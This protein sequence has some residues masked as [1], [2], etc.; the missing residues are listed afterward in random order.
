MFRSHS[1]QARSSR[2]PRSRLRR[3]PAARRARR[4]WLGAPL[5]LAAALALSG[6]ACAAPTAVLSATPAA[7]TPLAPASPALPLDPEVTTGTLANGLTYYLQQHET[8]DRRAHLMLIV[9]VG[10]VYE[11][12]DERG[13][14]HFIE[15]MAFNGTRR[16]EKATLVDFFEKSGLTFGSHANAA[17]AYDRTSYMLSIPT[18]D[19]K[20]L[21]TALDVLED[22]ASA[23][24]FAPEE[25]QKERQVLLSEWTSSK[26]ATR[27]VGEQLR[28]IL[29]AGSLFAEREVIGDEAVLTT[30]PPE[31]LVEFYRR[32]YRPERMAVVIVGDI[33][34]AALQAAIGERPAKPP[35]R[36]R[37]T[38]RCG[39]SQ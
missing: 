13:L 2:S 18:D 36:Q 24:S 30:A 27:R 15:H 38:C 21:G 37:S 5:P 10:S 8:K 34:P 4:R 19:P 32:W 6:A 39:S 12:D 16:F 33:D 31:R 22:W 23:L 9:K 14:A 25:V 17:T 1:P 7:P 29:L 35:R 20:L 28:R 26:G 3:L 11:R